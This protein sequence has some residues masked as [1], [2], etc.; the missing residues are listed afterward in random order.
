MGWAS[1]TADL[2]L[3]AETFQPAFALFHQSWDC[4]MAEGDDKTL[5]FRTSADFVAAYRS[6]DARIDALDM[7]AEVLKRAG[8]TE[9]AETAAA[10]KA[11]LIHELNDVILDEIERHWG[12]IALDCD[13]RI[14]TFPDE[15]RTMFFGR[16]LR[17]EYEERAA[18]K[19]D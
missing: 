16:F 13:P 8:Q 15:W 1:S 17:L 14:P 7:R 9:G 11:R 6:F 4:V 19:G 10:E 18:Y 3:C 5:V 2:G 12:P